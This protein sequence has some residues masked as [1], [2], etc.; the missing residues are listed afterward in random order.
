LKA[1]WFFVSFGSKITYSV[2]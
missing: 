1:L 2:G